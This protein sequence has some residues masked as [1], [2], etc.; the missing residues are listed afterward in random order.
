MDGR[1]H[2]PLDGSQQAT[3]ELLSE[4]TSLFADHLVPGLVGVAAELG[5]AD[6]VLHLL[7]DQAHP[8]TASV[9]RRSSHGDKKNR[10]K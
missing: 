9:M 6:A 1:G 5:T 2:Q 3:D 10:L 7:A 4:L 8:N